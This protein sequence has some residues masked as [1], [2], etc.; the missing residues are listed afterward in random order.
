MTCRE[1]SNPFDIIILLK[2]V[3]VLAP[4]GL[5]LKF[6]SVPNEMFRKVAH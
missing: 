3:C 2:P 6:T 1:S 4:K 5:A